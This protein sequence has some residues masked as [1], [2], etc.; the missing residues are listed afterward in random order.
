MQLFSIIPIDSYY[1]L[2][3]MNHI[4][5]NNAWLKQNKKGMIMNKN[6]ILNNAFAVRDL[7][8]EIENPSEKPLTVDELLSTVGLDSR[9]LL[10]M[11]D[12]VIDYLE[13][14]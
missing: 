12:N 6:E 3:I 5:R 8:L 9:T 1:E 11:Q 10:D 2:W 4:P 13:E 7:L 14:V